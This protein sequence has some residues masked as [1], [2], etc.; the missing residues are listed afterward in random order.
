MG[1]V[2][3]VSMVLIVLT[4]MVG[5]KAIKNE[6][7]GKKV[8]TFLGLNMLSF[9]GLLIGTTILLFSGSNVFAA[10]AAATAAA[11]DGLK[12]VGAGLSTGLSCIGTGIAVASSASAAI[13]AISEDS[14]LLGKTVIFVGLAEGIAIYGLIISI[15]I[16]S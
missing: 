12:Y 4:I 2:L 6:I 14:S 10:E 9:F 8:K 1:F 11:A 5:L 3:A 7:A 15:M 16:L 13:G